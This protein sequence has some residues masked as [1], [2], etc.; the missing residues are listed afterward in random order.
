[1]PL[2]FLDR[3][4]IVTTFLFILLGG[5]ILIRAALRAAPAFSF[6][7][8]AVFLAYGVYRARFVLRAFGNS[9]R[10]R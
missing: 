6:V 1:M 5:L 2:R 8:G 3:F 9:R 4:Q 10:P 7:I